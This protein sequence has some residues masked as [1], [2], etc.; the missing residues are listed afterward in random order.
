[1]VLKHVQTFFWRKIG[2]NVKTQ[3]NISFRSCGAS[4]RRIG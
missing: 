3:R 4:M 1:M 2:I